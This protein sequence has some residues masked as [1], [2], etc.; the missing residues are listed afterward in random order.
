MR[1]EIGRDVFPPPPRP[2]C[3]HP[4]NILTYVSPEDTN[5]ALQ[6]ALKR[7]TLILHDCFIYIYIISIIIIGKQIY[8]K[9][10]ATLWMFAYG[11]RDPLASLFR[12][13]FTH[14]QSSNVDNIN[15]FHTHIYKHIH[16]HYVR[17]MNAWRWTGR[18]G[19]RWEAGGKDV[20]RFSTFATRDGNAFVFRISLGE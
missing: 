14:P 17:E 20:G 11:V 6:N 10:I 12:P 1:L 18:N 19:I 2:S 8:T 7:T 5:A 4:K 15:P 9:H 3:T 13:D 16:P